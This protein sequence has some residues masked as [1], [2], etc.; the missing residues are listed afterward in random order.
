MES[1]KN[2]CSFRQKSTIEVRCRSERVNCGRCGSGK[3]N[4]S[5]NSGNGW[6][7]G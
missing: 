4:C 1:F 5:N 2:K 6:N 7:N 3:L